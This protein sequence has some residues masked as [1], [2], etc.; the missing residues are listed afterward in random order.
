MSPDAARA[1]RDWR[2]AHGLPQAPESDEAQAPARIGVVPAV[3]H[4]KSGGDA[5]SRCHGP[6]HPCVLDNEGNDDGD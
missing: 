4:A 5:K 6:D 2:R 3:T 1:I